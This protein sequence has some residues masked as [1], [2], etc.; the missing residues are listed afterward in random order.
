[1]TKSGALGT[2]GSKN[3]TGFGCTLATA[4]TGVAVDTAGPAGRVYVTDGANVAVINALAPGG[5]AGPTFYS[6]L[7]CYASPVGA[8]Q[9]LV[10]AATGNVFGAASGGFFPGIG[11][12]GQSIVPNP[13]FAIEVGGAHDGE[14]A[15]LVLGPGYLCPAATVLGVPFHLSPTPL[16]V[17]TTK[18]IDATGFASIPVPLGPSTPIGHTVFL[19]WGLISPTTL[20]ASS[21]RGMAL[22]TSLP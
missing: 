21:S 3:V 10:V 12:K 7:S 13:S 5:L 4:L 17:V 19:Q 16:T 20:A 22:T 2:F 6:P 15:V 8:I 1:V 14:I 11:H 18:I 9:G